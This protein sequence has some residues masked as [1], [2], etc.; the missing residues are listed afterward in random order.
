MNIEQFLDRCAGLIATGWTAEHWADGLIVLHAPERLITPAENPN[1]WSAVEA[2]WKMRNPHLS[3]RELD[4]REGTVPF[5]FQITVAADALGLSREDLA[6]L[7]SLFMND[8]RASDP[9]RK[10]LLSALGLA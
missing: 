1:H 6:I 4:E 8:L 3:R 9:L 2:V 5:R 7:C 10:R